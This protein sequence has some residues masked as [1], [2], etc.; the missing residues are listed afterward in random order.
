[1][2]NQKLTEEEIKSLQEIQQATQSL[3]NELGSLELTKIQ[4]ENRYDELVEYHTQLKQKE[5][6]L[7]K[8]LSDKYGNGTIDLDKG[9]FVASPQ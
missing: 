2:S 1:M 3:I 8:E 6:E 5:Q 4:I 7:G 9:E